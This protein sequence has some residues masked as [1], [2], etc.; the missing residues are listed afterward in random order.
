MFVDEKLRHVRNTWKTYYR[1]ATRVQRGAVRPE[2]AAARVDQCRTRGTTPCRTRTGVAAG[3]NY[4]ANGRRRQIAVVVQPESVVVQAQAVV[5]SVVQVA[6]GESAAPKAQRRKG[7]EVVNDDRQQQARWQRGEALPR[8][9]RRQQ[10]QT[11]GQFKYL[12]SFLLFSCV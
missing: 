5:A 10:W 9:R 8:L 11:V 7:P 4:D 2:P 3:G 12:H 1:A 6:G